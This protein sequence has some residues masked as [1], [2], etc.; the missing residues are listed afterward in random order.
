[1]GKQYENGNKGAKMIY[2]IR[3]QQK[4]RQL[5]VSTAQ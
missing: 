1:M 5:L 4:R 3:K 2:D